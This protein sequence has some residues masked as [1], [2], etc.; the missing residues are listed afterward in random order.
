MDF[1]ANRDK[2]RPFMTMLWFSEPH[3]PVV[4]ADEFIQPYRNEETVDAAKK[5]RYGGPQVI[6]KP[7]EAKRATY[8]GC[9]SMLDHH[10]GRLM[11]RLDEA[12]LRD[13]RSAN[14]MSGSG[15]APSSC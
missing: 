14:A 4:A 12:G 1:I 2:S 11:T 5:I 3:T 13:F 8:Y 10:I 6:R 9:V 15:V 7:D